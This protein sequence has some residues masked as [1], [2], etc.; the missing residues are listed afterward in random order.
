M[1]QDV[2]AASLR[3]LRAVSPHTCGP[4]HQLESSLLRQDLKVSQ[5]GAGSGTGPAADPTCYVK[6]SLE[7]SF[8]PQS[9][10]SATWT[11]Y[12]PEK[13]VERFKQC[14]PD[15]TA[16]YNP[17][18]V[19]R[20]LSKWWWKLDGDGQGC[21]GEGWGAGGGVGGIGVELVHCLS[22]SPAPCCASCWV[23]GTRA[24]GAGWWR[25]DE[26]RRWKVFISCEIQFPGKE[27][28]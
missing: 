11:Q 13:A 21:G 26:L 27:Q 22:H 9:S 8:C 15:E 23:L 10:S 14:T 16:W 12:L 3:V 17:R 18:L 2:G 19:T 6:K 24:A 4:G 25:S 5:G 28:L 20:E 7:R 1:C